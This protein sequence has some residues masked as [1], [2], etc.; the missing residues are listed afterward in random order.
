MAQ[1]IHPTALVDAGAKIA[2]N[3]QIGPY[4]IIGPDVTLEHDVVL[5]A[6]VC[7]S[8]VTTIGAR[9]RVA[10]F[11]S[12]GGAPQ[13]TGYKGEKTRLIIGTDCDFREHVT[14]NTGTVAGGGQTLVGNRVLLMVASHIA[15]D[16]IVGSDV[17]FANNAT[18]GGH[19]V[20]GD[21]VVIGGLSACHQFT[22]IGE[23]AMI[24][25]V[26][27]LREDVIPFA[28]VDRNGLIGGINVI[29]LKRR[30]ATKADIQIIRQT[31]RQI[32]LGEGHFE[33]RRQRAITNPPSNPFA[34][35][36][37]AF[38]AQSGTRPVL[39]FGRGIAINDSGVE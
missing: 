3:V 19:C 13:S 9:T 23:G 34:A 33:Q 6:H 24:G 28:L 2:A 37:V 11:C 5:S 1:N 8:G 4:C 21:R 32:F 31:V 14:I 20:V 15:H 12:L 10:P 35:M 16:C 38:L 27:C 18:L 39:K 7:V 29:G 25:G 30:G 17:T 26:V 36:I 22:R